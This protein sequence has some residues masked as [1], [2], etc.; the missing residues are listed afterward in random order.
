MFDS[1]GLTKGQTLTLWGNR[2]V[3]TTHTLELLMWLTVIFINFRGQRHA[4]VYW[5]SVLFLIANAI[6]IGC[7]VLD[8]WAVL[9]DQ[10]GLNSE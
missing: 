1:T 6:Y 9:G 8:N 4:F 10:K 2:I 3:I 7:D 5:L